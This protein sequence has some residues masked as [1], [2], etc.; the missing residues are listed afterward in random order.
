M[1]ELRRLLRTGALG[2][3]LQIEANF[4]QDKFLALPSDNWRLSGTEAPAGPDDRNRHP[5]A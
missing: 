3:P 1:A 2:T 4:S 5:F